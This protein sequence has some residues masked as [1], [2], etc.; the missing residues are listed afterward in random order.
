MK[1]E[2]SKPKSPVKRS[3]KKS[4]GINK[5]NKGITLKQ[6]DFTSLIAK[7]TNI[8]PAIIGLTEIETGKI[9]DVNKHF[10]DTLGFK[11]KEVIG[12]VSSDLLNFKEEIRKPIISKLVKE[13]SVLGEEII[14]H[15]KNGTPLNFIVFSKLIF[16]NKK[17]YNLFFA[18]D[19]TYKKLADDMHKQSEAWLM[20]LIDNID[21]LFTVIDAKTYDVLY[22]N[23][24]MI[25]KYGDY[26]GKKCY[27]RFHNIDYVCTHCNS[28]N[29]LGK[30]SG[31]TYEYEHYEESEDKW[32]KCKSKA[33]PWTN[34]IVAIN[35][36]WSDITKQ[37]KVE[38]E[39]R[40][41][42]Y[43]LDAT[44]HISKIGGWL[45]DLED[46]SMFWSEEAY[47]IHGLN[48]ED[49]ENGASRHII[50]SLECY[51]KE[52]KQIIYEA[53]KKCYE[54]GIPYTFEF[55]FKTYDGRNIWIETSG[56][57]IYKDNKIVKVIGNIIDITEAK[58]T[59]TM[60]Y[61]SLEV[62][63]LLQKA[64]N[65]VIWNWDIIN[66]KQ[67]WNKAGKEVLGWDDI[68]EEPQTAQ[69]WIDKN[70]PDDS[71]RI[72]EKFFQS[73]KDKEC[74]SWSDEYK[75][76]KK[77]GEYAQILDRCYILRD[78]EGNAIRMVGAMLDITERKKME[79]EL[80]SAKEKAEESERLK[81][82][83]LENMSHEIRTPMNG[84]LGFL[85]LLREPD[86]SEENRNEFIEVVNKAGE[87]LL[88][89][90][91]DIIE[92]SKIESGETQVELTNV[93]ISE[94]LENHYNFFKHQTDKKGIDFIFNN[95]LK[96]QPIIAKTDKHKFDSIISNLIKNAIKFTKK[97]SIKLGMYI[98]DEFITFYVKDTGIGIPEEV[99]SKIFNR[100]VQAD[101]S[102][103]RPFEGSGL[104]LSIV[105]AYIEMLHGKI[106]LKSEVG[107]GSSFFFSIPLISSDER[108]P[109]TETNEIH[110]KLPDEKT[111]ILIAED[112]DLSFSFVEQILTSRNMKVIRTTNG[113]DT[114]KTFKENPDISLILMDIQLPGMDGIQATKQIRKFD[115][116]IPI[117]AQTAYAMEGDKDTFL[118]AGCSDYIS[119]PMNIQ[120]L[121]KV[122]AKN[123]MD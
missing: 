56:M 114:V 50:K 84:I 54:E 34:G 24:A 63:N 53:F 115:K 102:Y 15:T 82:C 83:F 37:K 80:I 87:R 89:T 66:N 67:M 109:E 2:N 40:D 45:W 123:L 4:T 91:N 21:D 42:K 20:N 48:P 27:E 12:K 70:H 88:D 39:L 99:R 49:I 104:G 118:N 43:L 32:Y 8:A 72:S 33:I 17:K 95:Y 122:I 79:L 73:I 107:K 120:N 92:I 57:P 36:I 75:F 64:T 60:L 93:D 113:N 3:S 18:I 101:G 81:S 90:I 16:I 105:K 112:D 28:E 22:A 30:N 76:L 7:I 47:K 59:K 86:L 13:G 108:T 55:P 100:F 74:I 6:I 94:L 68:T 71:E 69:W 58:K 25:N 38:N 85:D 103:N 46:Q 44:Q 110:Y 19:I 116:E 78:K 11:H 62:F 41:Y 14:A 31:K 77:N 10:C 61:E 117:I 97:G 106:R 119:K 98:E 23:K 29:V 9:I 1:K 111:T 5:G 26:K 96:G 35:V 52:D 65:D 51:K 121:L